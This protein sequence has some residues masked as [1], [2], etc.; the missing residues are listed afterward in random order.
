VRVT[1]ETVEPVIYYDQLQISNEL[2]A[3]M[4]TLRG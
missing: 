1:T 2:V 3:E 4:A